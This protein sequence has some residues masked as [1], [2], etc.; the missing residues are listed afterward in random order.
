MTGR[1]SWIA[2][3]LPEILRAFY[4]FAASDFAHVSRYA[5]RVAARATKAAATTNSATRSGQMKRR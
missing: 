5:P 2:F 1:E 3:E 4:D